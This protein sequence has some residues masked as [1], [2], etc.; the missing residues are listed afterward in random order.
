VGKFGE[1]HGFGPSFGTYFDHFILLL[2]WGFG[3]LGVVMGGDF[4]GR[5]FNFVL[6]GVLGGYGNLL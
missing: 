1:V 4:W 2:F 5:I 3:V 6:C